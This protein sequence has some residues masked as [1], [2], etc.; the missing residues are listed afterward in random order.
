[1][2]E[3]ESD[4]KEFVSSNPNPEVSVETVKKNSIT[5]ALGIQKKR[6][7]STPI[8]LKSGTTRKE[9][10]ASLGGQSLMFHLGNNFSVLI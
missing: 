5:Q 3:S 10:D 7:S 8:P 4:P 1:V 9:P 6:S 2:I